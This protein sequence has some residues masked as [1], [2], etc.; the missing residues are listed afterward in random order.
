MLAL[1]A[2]LLKRGYEVHVFELIGLVAGQAGFAEEFAGRGVKLWR[3]S[4]FFTPAE[5]LFPDAPIPALQPFAP[6][7]PAKIATLCRALMVV[8]REFRPGVVH[9][10]SHLANLIGG[11]VSSSVDVP[12]VVLSQRVSPP[13]FWF[14]A[15]E[16]DLYREAYR[17]L[18]RDSR[19]VFVN[20]SSSSKAEYERWMQLADSAIRLVHNGFLPS[21]MNL[22]GGG[23][24][25]ASRAKL[26]L[27][28]D[29]PVVGTLM[30][31]AP[32]KDPDLWLETAAVIASSR[33]DVCFL[34]AGYGH[35]AIAEQLFQKATKLGFGHRLV[36]PGAVSD[37]AQ[38]YS[39]MDVFLLSSRSDNLPNVLIEAQ[40]AGISVVG[41]AVGGVGEAMLDGLT[42]LLVRDR[43]ARN[44]A[45]AVLGI[46]GDPRWRARAAVQGPGFVADKFDCERMVRETAAIYRYR[47]TG[48]G[49]F[50]RSN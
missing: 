38:I 46:L 20:N 47:R 30:R 45:S 4:D 44:L 3:A 37:I 43:S 27:P 28:A 6:L 25:A 42:G 32:E 24:R 23:G 19:I 12:R 35:G 13:S 34:L 8:I 11:F 41:P 2:G 9:C 10:W 14:A 29:G 22:D 15:P 1:A 16:A 36:M 49:L 31:L 5:V 40:A 17:A 50:G 21:S 7:L 33:P 48:R 26:G 18:V 39:A